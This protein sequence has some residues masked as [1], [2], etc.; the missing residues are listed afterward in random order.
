MLPLYF[1]YGP[2]TH[3][4]DEHVT[5]NKYYVNNILFISFFM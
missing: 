4:R 2:V 1:L 5:L 3:S